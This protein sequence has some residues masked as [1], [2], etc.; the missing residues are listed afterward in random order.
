[1]CSLAA[2]PS[3]TQAKLSAAGLAEDDVCKFC[4]GARGTLFHRAFEC[5]VGDSCRR[6][7]GDEEVLQAAAEVRLCGAGVAELFARG[8]LPLPADW[9]PR[10]LTSDSAEVQWINRPADGLLK[11]KIFADGSA[12]FGHIPALA[13]AGWSLVSVDQRGALV[14]A[15]FGAVPVD[16]APLQRARDGEDYALF[17]AVTLCDFGVELWFDCAGTISTARA[18]PEVGTAARHPGAHLW[19]HIFARFEGSLGGILHNTLGHATEKDIEA[20]RS[21]WWERNANKQA[22]EL[23]K[24]GARLHGVTDQALGEVRAILAFQQR[25]VSF[26]G[27]H[28]AWLV[29]NGLCDHTELQGR[30]REAAEK[31]GKPLQLGAW[32]QRTGAEMGAGAWK[33]EQ[34]EVFAA[35]QLQQATGHRI[36]AAACL[37]PLA[38]TV[39]LC[40]RCG[41]YSTTKI[42]FLGKPCRG[43]QSR[44][45]AAT[46]RIQRFLNGE[47][48][49][50][51][52]ERL[53]TVW[54][55]P[56]AISSWFLRRACGGATA[57]GGGWEGLSSAGEPGGSQYR[58]AFL[59]AIGLTPARLSEMVLVQEAARSRGRGHVVADDDLL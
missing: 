48:P 39:L 4:S 42:D 13:R 17:M 22:D 54:C 10:P 7:F 37:P 33:E 30:K 56:V 55:P 53:G 43:G 29:D 34:A 31:A 32:L 28:T 19:G 40:T 12:Y 38:G 24:R 2:G 8:L 36:R 51:T 41:G 44:V 47:H 21:T 23:A 58:Q 11:G 18:G 5:W 6:A 26:L 57:S 25:I 20:G 46:R 15:A 52:E 3:W 9:L 14:S 59:A 1:M 49:F 27:Y 35:H 45:Q 50:E 16:R